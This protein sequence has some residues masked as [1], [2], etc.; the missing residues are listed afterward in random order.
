[1]SKLTI[2][3]AAVNGYTHV[4]TADFNDLIAIGNGGQ[5][6]IAVVPAGAAVELVTV[7]EKTAFVGTTSL[8]IDIGTT[9]GDPDEYIDALDVDAM[10]VPVSNTGDV[11]TTTQS[12]A[13]GVAADT[14]VLLEVTDAAIASASAGEIVVGLRIA[15]L[16]QF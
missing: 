4:Y 8:V 6:T 9:G 15:D 11:F 2:N 13:V 12:Q 1:M 5:A 16:S 7:L 14:P 10:T 3:E